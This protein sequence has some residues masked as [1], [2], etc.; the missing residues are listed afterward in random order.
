MFT[1]LAL[2]APVVLVV[3]I[4]ALLK[5]ALPATPRQTTRVAPPRTASAREPVQSL[6]SMDRRAA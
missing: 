6:G 3:L 4:Y 2:I 5:L 1:A